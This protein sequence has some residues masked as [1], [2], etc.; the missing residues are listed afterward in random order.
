MKVLL[1]PHGSV[2]IWFPNLG[3]TQR[4]AR[5]DSSTLRYD[6]CNLQPNESP[7][8]LF[9]GTPLN[10]CHLCN[11]GLSRTVGIKPIDALIY[12]NRIPQKCLSK[13]LCRR[14][15]GGM[16]FVFV[17]VQAFFCKLPFEDPTRNCKRE[18]RNLPYVHRLLASQHTLANL[19]VVAE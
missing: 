4:L 13:C 2:M 9:S 14:R 6:R 17:P 8:V 1:H 16:P 19:D 12:H 11:C 3:V 15:T 5:L 7:S 18:L 10:H